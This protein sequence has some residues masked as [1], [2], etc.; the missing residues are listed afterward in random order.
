MTPQVNIRKLKLLCLTLLIFIVPQAWAAA[1]VTITSAATSG[2]HSFRTDALTVTNAPAV[3]TQKLAQRI[4]GFIEQ[5]LEWSIRRVNVRFYVDDG[6]FAKANRLSS[7]AVDA[8]TYGSDQ[9]V[10]ISPRVPPEA[11]PGV[12]AHELTHVVL[13]QKY[14]KSAS[15]AAI[16]PWLEEG[17][18]NFLSR[19]AGAKLVFTGRGAVDYGAL[20]RL[21]PVD[22]YS[23]SHPVAQ[24][25]A[26][27]PGGSWTTPDVRAVRL[28]YMASTA[29]MDMLAARCDWR[30]L[31][32][33]SI[34]KNLDVY[35]KNTCGIA[36]VNS[37]FSEWVRQRGKPSANRK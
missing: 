25:E 19:R 8:L 21:M 9:S 5:E 29:L 37:A 36:D 32:Q 13:F 3:F 11:V 1:P 23:L 34:G 7:S 28:R 17:L 10:H 33:L 22:A 24:Q 26:A 12:I 16:P 6:A 15:S 31:L 2:T 4:T 30:D 18:A 20:T 35:I 14:N 27:V